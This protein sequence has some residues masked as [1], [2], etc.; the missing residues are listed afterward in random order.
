MLNTTAIINPLLEQICTLASACDDAGINV[1][2]TPM[3]NYISVTCVAENMNR[4][5]DLDASDAMSRLSCV[6]KE[7]ESILPAQSAMNGAS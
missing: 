4:V 6:K 2:I 7:L 5:I 1:A 3:K